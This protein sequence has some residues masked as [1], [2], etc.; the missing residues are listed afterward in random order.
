MS[1]ELIRLE[2][3]AIN[4]MEE[5]DVERFSFERVVYD[6]ST[7]WYRVCLQDNYA[8]EYDELVF[9]AMHNGEIVREIQ[10]TSRIYDENNNDAPV[11]HYKHVF[12]PNTITVIG[13]DVFDNFVDL[14][15]CYLPRSVMNIGTYLF[16]NCANLR[17][18]TIDADSTVTLIPAYMFDNC[19]N[20]EYVTI[21]K[22]VS[23]I[24]DNAFR[25]CDSLNTIVFGGT[26]SE[27]NAITVSSTGNSAL[28]GATKIYLGG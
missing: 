27:W 18:V 2:N 21:P 12:L 4:I 20:L 7:S 14:E 8:E 19:E 6:S 28:D 24:G 16:R 3:I 11:V 17:T 10:P 22:T 5:A 25:G 26:Q 1:K 13:N 9:P 23:S 15:T